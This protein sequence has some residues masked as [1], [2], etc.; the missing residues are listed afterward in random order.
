MFG[1][2]NIQD[3]TIYARRTSATRTG[4][5]GES[6][7]ATGWCDS[8]PSS[9]YCRCKNRVL[10][11][12]TVEDEI[13]VSAGTSLRKRRRAKKQSLFSFTSYSAISAVRIGLLAGEEGQASSDMS[14]RSSTDFYSLV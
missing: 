9:C 8:L 10:I 14:D 12:Q 11:S 1:P 2:A 3:I 6:L 7:R 13:K 4:M 5:P